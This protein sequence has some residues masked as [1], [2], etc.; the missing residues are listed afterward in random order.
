MSPASPRRVRDPL[1]NGGG[2]LIDHTV[3][4]ADIIRWVTGADFATAK[5]EIATGLRP[6]QAEDLG[7][8]HGQ[9]TNGTIYQ[10]DASWS[11]RAADPMWGDV[12]MRVVGSEGTASLDLYNNQ[13]IEIYHSG[14]VTLRYPNYL[15]RE[16]GEIFLDYAESRERSKPSINAN[17]IDGLRT[18]ELV[19][20]G[21]KS[22]KNG[23]RVDVE[24]WDPGNP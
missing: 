16:H 4:V 17:A 24:I 12:T 2:C 20:A 3:H 14:N 22:A 9:L 6:L 15:L 18:I 5:A 8:L 11:R 13:Q 1:E 21:Y 23:R 7:I 10:I 19:F